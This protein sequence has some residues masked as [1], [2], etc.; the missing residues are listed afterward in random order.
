MIYIFHGPNTEASYNRLKSV[1]QKFEIREKLRL[2][3]EHLYEDLVQ[4][5][6]T[7]STL[8]NVKLIIVQNFIK[9][10]KI[11]FKNQIWQ[12]DILDK[13]VIFYESSL[14]TPQTS[15]KLPK[16]FQIEVFKDEP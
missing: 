10:K 6:F 13:T 5:V 8:E 3:K 9:D 4:A 7:T 12:K 2:G 11:D 1:D 15:A 14:L 16:H